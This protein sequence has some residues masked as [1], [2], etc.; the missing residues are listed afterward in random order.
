M[1]LVDSAT[2]EIVGRTLQECE[3]VIARGLATFVEVGEALAE[4]RDSRLYR[5]SFD[6]FEDYCR[7]RWGLSRPRSYEL[8]D[9]ARVANALSGI[10][11]TPKPANAGQ[12]AALRPV[13]DEPEKMAEAMR[14]ASEATGGKLTAA[15][16]AEA[17]SDLV[18]STEQKKQDAAE[19]RALMDELQPEGFDPKENQRIVTL[20]GRFSAICRELTALGDPAVVVRDLA[21]ADRPDRFRAAAEQAY[22]WLDT[23]VIEWGEQTS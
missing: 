2:G 13:K 19:L 1:A 6:N 4:V 12:A 22:G 10:P 21:S 9:A 23:F 17:V 20:R 3:Q 16:I 14:S 15:A 5:E 7:E 18:A 8:I 11:D